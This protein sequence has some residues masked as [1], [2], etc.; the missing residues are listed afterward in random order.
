MT[1]TF[2]AGVNW[3]ATPYYGASPLTVAF[4]SAGSTDPD[5]TIVS[6]DWDFGDGSTHATVASPPA[7]TYTA[8][9]NYNAKL[10]VT[11]NRGGTNTTATS[12]PVAATASP[13][14]LKTGIGAWPSTSTTALRSWSFARSS[15][16]RVRRPRPAMGWA[17]RTRSP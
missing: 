7:H 5:G 17:A 3:A 14:E 8:I 4:S 12:A 11:D 2:T 15:P 9:G 6:Y 13:T 1:I 16:R 10:T